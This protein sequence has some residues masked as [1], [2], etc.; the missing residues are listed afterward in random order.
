ML[1]ELAA[2]IVDGWQRG[3][4]FENSLSRQFSGEVFVGIEKLKEAA[5]GINVII[6]K[7]NLTRLCNVSSSHWH[8]KNRDMAHTTYQEHFVMRQDLRYHHQQSFYR[9]PQSKGSGLTELD[10][11]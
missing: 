2:R 8:C 1:E 6:W 10:A 11:R 7:F 9:H 4:G 5:D 3:I